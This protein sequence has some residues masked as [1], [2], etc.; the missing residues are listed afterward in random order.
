MEK[1]IG[2]LAFFGEFEYFVNGREIFR[3]SVSNPI[4]TKGFRQG[5]RFE[6]FLEQW[7]TLLAIL[8]KGAN[9]EVAPFFSGCNGRIVDRFQIRCSL[10]SGWYIFDTDKSEAV[11]WKTARREG[12]YYAKVTKAEA[13]RLI[14]NRG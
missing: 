4:D 14:I 5:A 3:A 12:I 1:S 7:G 2:H 8:E 6:C 11:V 9:R 13:D 10:G